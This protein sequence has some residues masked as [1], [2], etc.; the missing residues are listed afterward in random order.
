ML[1]LIGGPQAIIDLPTN[2][3]S[4]VVVV[5]F[6]SIIIPMMI[7]SLH[8]AVNNLE[9]FLPEVKNSSKTMSYLKTALLFILSPVQSVLLEVHHLQTAEEAR[10]LAQNY[11]IEAIQKKRQSRNIQKQM[12]SFG[13][14]ELG[15]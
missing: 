8:L 1:G 14:I 4:V 13:R 15:S 6:G 10:E 5:M 2:F 11:N 9:M 3:G 7:S 12:T